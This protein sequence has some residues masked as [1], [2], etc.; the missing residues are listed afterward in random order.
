MEKTDRNYCFQD[1]AD[2]SPFTL[3]KGVALIRKK[4]NSSALQDCIKNPDQ[5][6]N[7]S[8]IMKDSRTTKAGIIKL[9]DDQEV[10]V[11]CF[12]NKGFVYSMKYMLRE[13]R[14]FRVW[15]VAWAMEKAGIPT[16]RPM[17]AIANYKCGFPGNAYLIRHVVPDIV[18]TLDFF[19]KLKDNAELQESYIE[20]VAAMFAKMHDAG[21]YHGDAKCSNIYVEDCG[22]D[23]F[24]YGVWDL[25]SCRTGNKPISEDLREKEISRIA[26]SFAEISNRNDITVAESE[27]KQQLNDKY[28]NFKN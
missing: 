3:E 20:T 13:A 23:K 4:D 22:N 6:L 1:N 26:W 28:L 2:F 10:F 21:I 12:N 27:I 25:L 19:A 8:E 14:P 9:A 17:A 16:P 11:K 24:A 5:W 18:P 7:D 15:R